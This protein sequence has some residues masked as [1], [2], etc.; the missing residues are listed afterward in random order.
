M[1][2]AWLPWFLIGAALA[3]GGAFLFGQQDG[4]ARCEARHTADLVKQQADSIND[5]EADKAKETDRLAIE[6]ERRRFSRELEDLAFAD[7]VQS[8]ACLSADRVRRIDRR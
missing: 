6:A 5:A 4:R 1:P 2:R 7:P 3:C 8:P